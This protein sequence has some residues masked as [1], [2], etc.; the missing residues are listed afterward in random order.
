MNLEKRFTMK[1]GEGFTL[2]ELLVVIAII[3]ILAGMLLPA[4]SKAKMA[5]QKTICVNNLH[6]LNVAATMYSSDYNDKFVGNNQGDGGATDAS[7]RVQLSWVKGSY[8]GSLMDQTNT[9]ML[10]SET[11]S[12]LASYIK[13]FKIY[14]CPGDREKVAIVSGGPTR[15]DTL[16]SYG[17]N[18]F[19]GWNQA[20]DYRGNPA[21]GYRRFN[22][23]GDVTGISPSDIMMFIDMNPRSLCRP[24]FGFYMP[25]VPAGTPNDTFYHMPAIAHNAGGVNSYVD[26]S[27]SP[28][29]WKDKDTRNPR[30]VD[31]GHSFSDPGNVD[32][33]W[34]QRHASVRK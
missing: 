12:L 13:D 25:S 17:M 27:V 7:G 18:A 31:H 28:Q 20:S 22:S 2:I 26:G 30:N 3:A 21:P 11:Q 24:F 15:Y 34:L 4:L 5:G 19:V 14:K 9:L 8:E 33:R 29:R 23:L 10:I 1:R 6:Q 16:R 32:V